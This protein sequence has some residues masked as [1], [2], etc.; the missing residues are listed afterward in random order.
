MGWIGMIPQRKSLKSPNIGMKGMWMFS[1]LLVIL[2]VLVS[3]II[4]VVLW[5][6]WANRRDRSKDELG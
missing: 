1:F 6:Y 5:V 2:G 4:L 3:P